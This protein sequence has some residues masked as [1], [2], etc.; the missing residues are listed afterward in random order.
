MLIY[1]ILR[2]E[3]PMA[4]NHDNHLD[5]LDL[6]CT[7]ITIRLYI[8]QGV[9]VPEIDVR[10]K[11]PS[12]IRVR[13]FPGGLDIPVMDTLLL[14][15]GKRQSDRTVMDT[16]LLRDGSRKCHERSRYIAEWLA[17]YFSLKIQI[18]IHD[19]EQLPNIND[20][21]FQEPYV[22]WIADY[23]LTGSIFVRT[24]F[25]EYKDVTFGYDIP[26]K[27]YGTW[28]RNVSVHR[29]HVPRELKPAIVTFIE[30]DYFKMRRFECMR[31]SWRLGFKAGWDI[32]KYGK[33]LSALRLSKEG[34]VHRNGIDIPILDQRGSI[35]LNRWTQLEKVKSIT[36]AYPCFTDSII[37]HEVGHMPDIDDPFFVL[38]YKIA[39]L[40]VI[41]LTPGRE[42]VLHIN[43]PHPGDITFSMP[44]YDEIVFGEIPPMYATWDSPFVTETIR[45]ADDNCP[46]CLDPMNGTEVPMYENYQ[47][48]KIHP[49]CM[50]RLLETNP[51]A[52]HPTSR[53]P[54]STMNRA[55]I[56]RAN[57]YGGQY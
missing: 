48:R 16:L 43:F 13:W 19:V 29:K 23:L 12:D 22:A 24:N 3:R 15:D 53:R 50:K 51:Y 11:V 27:P 35:P 21:F 54:I 46:I 52:R 26:T 20:P 14:I 31:V 18:I 57:E 44:K 55:L 41:R 34:T 40:D 49:Q 4:N 38:Y 36:S 39:F 7:G 47:L 25:P 28:D 37:L 45:N 30:P 1:A 32:K 6:E 9:T 33:R 5:E 2:R 8:P 56:E 10:R 17:A 42:F